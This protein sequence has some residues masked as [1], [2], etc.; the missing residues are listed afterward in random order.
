[1]KT[2]YFERIAQ[3]MQ[4]RVG[5]CQVCPKEVVDLCQRLVSKKVQ[6]PCAIAEFVLGQVVEQVKSKRG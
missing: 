4:Q 3:L 5:D 1:M 6:C 2:K